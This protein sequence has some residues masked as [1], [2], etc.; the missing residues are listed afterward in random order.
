M[1]FIGDLRILRQLVSGVSGT[2]QH[3]ARL[4]QFYGAQADDYDRFRARLLPG[5][6]ELLEQ[7]EVP[8]GARVVDMGGG[9]GAN[10]ELFGQHHHVARWTIVDLSPSLLRVARQRCEQHGL[11]TR[12]RGGSRRLRLDVEE[13]PTSRFFPIR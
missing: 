3:A 4:E 10:L 9:T 8:A 12:R 1:S 13:P 11:S 5:R 2:S 6:Q 7:I